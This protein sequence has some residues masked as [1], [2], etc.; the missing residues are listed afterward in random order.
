MPDRGEPVSESPL[1]LVIEDEYLLHAAVE[2]ALNEAGFAA[3]IAPSGEEALT[4]FM[5]QTKNY[6]ALITDINLR[7]KLTG[8]EVAHR[9]REKEGTL[10]IIYMTGAAADQWT[11]Q[12]VPNSILIQKPFAPAQLITALSNLLNVGSTSAGSQ[13]S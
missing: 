7:G 8:W 13:P 11:A 2:D 9:I 3:D 4:L 10:P 5:G 6:K 1:V 12:G